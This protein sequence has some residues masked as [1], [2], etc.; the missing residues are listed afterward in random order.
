M[1]NLIDYY[2]TKATENE[3]F[4]MLYVPIIIFVITGLFF[5]GFI[6]SNDMKSSPP[7]PLLHESGPS[8]FLHT[9]E[10]VVETPDPPVVE[11]NSVESQSDPNQSINITGTNT[12][13]YINGKKIQ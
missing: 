10:P 5:I 8:P 2:K 7:S 9:S 12:T 13:I 6:I 1:K 4:L 3:R 11:F